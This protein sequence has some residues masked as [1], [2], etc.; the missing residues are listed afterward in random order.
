MTNRILIR[1]SHQNGFPWRRASTRVNKDNKKEK[2]KE[3]E[4]IGH[5]K[6]PL[7]EW[8]HRSIDDS[9]ERS[10]SQSTISIRWINHFRSQQWTN[11]SAE[12]K[13]RNRQKCEAYQ[14]IAIE[15]ASLRERRRFAYN[16]PIASFHSSV[17]IVPIANTRGRERDLLVGSTVVSPAMSISFID[18]GVLDDH[19]FYGMLLLLPRSLNTFSLRQ[20][21]PFIRA[22][23]A[24]EDFFLLPASWVV[25][26]FTSTRYAPDSRFILMPS[27]DIIHQTSLFLLVVLGSSTHLTFWFHWLKRLRDFCSFSERMS[28]MDIQFDFC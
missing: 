26:V 3:K 13:M 6:N 21:T 10:Y 22:Q 20:P 24:W 27:F 25:R 4:N 2:M 14:H 5:S 8:R 18:D 9:R 28:L 11:G 1:T 16:W 7:R 15:M 19:S 23:V 12:K 17:G